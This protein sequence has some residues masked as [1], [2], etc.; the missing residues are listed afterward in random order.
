MCANPGRAPQRYR[1][2]VVFTFENRTWDD[3]GLGFGSDMPYLHGLGQQCSYFTDWTETDT[4][5]NSLTQYVG[6]ITGAFQ[7]GTVDDCSPSASCSTRADNLFRQARRSSLAAINFVEGATTGCSATGNAAKHVPVLYL[8][9]ADDRAHC[10]A[11]VRP[12]GDFNPAAL[13]AFSFV[14]PTLCNDGHDCSNTVVDAWAKEH[15]QPVL[16]SSA[17]RAGQV[18]VFIWYDEDH[19]VPNLWITPTANAGAIA[20]PGAGYA[21]TLKAWESMLGLPCLANACTAPD[22][23]TPANS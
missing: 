3:V 11:Q 18:A 4:A 13:P 1:S 2:V 23:R 15:V 8:W 21:S 10:T 22:M 16:E 17:Y 12:F 5:Q 19:P 6:Q 14:T 7:S 20:T 9:G